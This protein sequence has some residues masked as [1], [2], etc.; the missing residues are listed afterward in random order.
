MTIVKRTTKGS[1]LTYAE[2]DENIRD[3]HEDTTLDRVTGNGNTTTNNVSVGDINA[4]DVSVGEL[5]TTK[6]KYPTIPVFS[7]Y[8]LDDGTGDE[9]PITGSTGQLT[10][11]ATNTSVN[12]GTC[13][14]T[15]N[16]RFTAPIAGIYYFS[17]HLSLYNNAA[18][19]ND[20]SVGWGLYKNGTALNF[21]NY[22]SGQAVTQSTP[23]VIGAQTD[24]TISTQAHEIGAP[25]FSAYHQLAVNDYITVGWINMSKD[26]GVRSFL[27]NGHL[28]TA[29]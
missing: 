1:A 5:T 16:G 12:V 9:F 8:R 25:S 4:N 28:I 14:N 23:H 21:T 27:F 26:L 22:T 20:N 13:F 19:N 6:F 17:F 18:D 15:T 7:A 3:L 29:V 11:C 10:T 24:G 2:M